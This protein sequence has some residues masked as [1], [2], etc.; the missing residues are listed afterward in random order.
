MIDPEK[1]EDRLD[2]LETLVDMKAK[3]EQP[4][5]WEQVESDEESDMTS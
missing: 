2:L 4:I 1:L 3:G 5:A